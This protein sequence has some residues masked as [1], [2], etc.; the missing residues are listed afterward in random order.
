MIAAKRAHRA[1]LSIS[2]LLAAGYGALQRGL[3]VGDKGT[4]VALAGVLV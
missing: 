3:H 2:P 1:P 4:I